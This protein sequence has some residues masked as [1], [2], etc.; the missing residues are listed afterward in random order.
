MSVLALYPG[1]HRMLKGYGGETEHRGHTHLSLCSFTCLLPFIPSGVP[2][3]WMDRGS[4]MISC[5]QIRS[6]F[7]FLRIY[8]WIEQCESK[9]S[10][11]FL[12]LTL[13]TIIQLHTPTYGPRTS[14]RRLYFITVCYRMEQAWMKKGSR[15]KSK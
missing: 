3:G 12:T 11:Q 2:R 6:L 1:A 10:K 8:V 14:V 15:W 13:R 9:E 5:R 7:L 4:D